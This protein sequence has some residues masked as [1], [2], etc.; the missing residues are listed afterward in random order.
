MSSSTSV[1][2]VGSGVIG[3]SAALSLQKSGLSVRVIDR[4]SHVQSASEGNAGAFALADIVPL[5]TPGIM[6]AA[7]RW[8][9]D[10]LGP[11]SIPPSY[12]FAI[13]PWLLR[14]WRASWSDKFP[15]LMRAQAELMALSRSALDNLAN[16]DDFE[17]LLRREGQL[18]V[19][20]DKK[21][22]RNSLGYWKSCEEFSVSHHLLESSDEIA[23]IQPGLCSRFKYA[24]Y[25]PDWINVEDP[26]L[27]LKNLRDRFIAR[28]GAVDQR[29]VISLKGN[30]ESVVVKFESGEL[31]SDYVVVAAGAWSNVL[32]KTVGDDLPLETERGYNTT[33]D[34]GSFELRTHL[35]FA[36]HGF[37]VSKVGSGLRVGG[38]VELG[39]L[40]APP[41][42]ERSRILLSKAK[43]FIPSMD[44]N[45]C[46]E[47][48]GFRP[49]MP[50]SLPVIGPSVKQ[51]R[52]IYAFGHGHL[53]LTQSAGTGELI[54]DTILGKPWPIPSDPFSP[55]RFSGVFFS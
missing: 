25:T 5:A 7:P 49:S 37:V 39:G 9:F 30:S 33:F 53:G 18:R 43:Q 32:A 41:N 44:S 50:D 6:K 24:G 21:S 27:W 10:P 28:G 52:V 14:F 13:A 36:D 29:N 20:D 47:W 3:L 42:F 38:A 11:L 48:M 17:H 26:K 1:I 19:Y 16:H 12:V 46:E 8:L 2:V 23:E 51:P 34:P 55:R 45:M 54:R 22:F 4:G 35:T 31:R 15:S 40:S